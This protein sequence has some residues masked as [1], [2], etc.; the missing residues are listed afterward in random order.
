MYYRI[1]DPYKRTVARHDGGYLIIHATAV[2]YPNRD[3][4]IYDPITGLWYQ[5]QGQ[6]W[7]DL[8]DQQR[9]A[10]HGKLMMLEINPDDPELQEIPNP[11]LKV[12]P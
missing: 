12:I 7:N 10:Y 3:I 1:M 9:A 11:E 4:K 5:M 8:I 2:A 6:H